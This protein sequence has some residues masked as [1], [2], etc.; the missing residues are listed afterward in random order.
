MTLETKQDVQALLQQAREL[1]EQERP[2]N[3]VKSKLLEA[4]QRSQGNSELLGQARALSPQLI[5]RRTAVVDA[6]FKAAQEMTDQTPLD[7]GSIRDKLRRARTLAI[8]V[9]DAEANAKVIENKLKIVED[10]ALAR[11]ELDTLDKELKEL[12]QKGNAEFR[13]NSSQ[14]EIVAEYFQ[15]AHKRAEH[16]AASHQPPLPLA[17]EFQNLLKL[18]KIEYDRAR[19]HA[20]MQTTYMAVG[21]F[22]EMLSG[23]EAIKRED[24]DRRVEIEDERGQVRNILVDDAIRITRLR[25]GEASQKRVMDPETGYLAEARRYLNEHDPSAADNKLREAEGFPH[26]PDDAKSAINALK[27]KEVQPALRLYQRAQQSALNALS[28]TNLASAWQHLKTAEKEYEWASNIRRARDEVRKRARHEFDERVNRIKD[29]IED[30]KLDQGEIALEELRRTDG[31]EEILGN[32]ATNLRELEERIRKIREEALHIDSVRTAVQQ[33]V[34]AGDYRPAND[35]LTTFLENFPNAERRDKVLGN[36]YR[37]VQLQLDMARRPVLLQES[38]ESNDRE[39]TFDAL[40]QARQAL[41][42]QPDL[43]RT[44]EIDKIKN[45]LEGRWTLLD[46]EFD[47]YQNDDR[48]TALQKLHKVKTSGIFEAKD[49]QRAEELIDQI[50]RTDILEHNL[51]RLMPEVETRLNDEDYLEA[52]ELLS[53]LIEGSLVSREVRKSRDIAWGRITD[54]LIRQTIDDLKRFIDNQLKDLDQLVRLR[55]QLSKLGAQNIE[56]LQNRVEERIAVLRAERSETVKEWEN[57]Q[58]SWERALH[59]NDASVE[60]RQRFQEARRNNVRSQINR[61]TVQVDTFADALQVASNYMQTMPDYIE[62]RLWYLDVLILRANAAETPEQFDNAWRQAQSHC[63]LSLFL[64][65]RQPEQTKEEKVEVAAQQ[66]LDKLAK[67]IVTDLGHAQTV[68]RFERLLKPK[69]DLATLRAA[70]T[71]LDTFVA[72]HTKYQGISRW[73]TRICRPSLVESL[74]KSANEKGEEFWEAFID[75][76][77]IRAVVPDHDEARRYL[78]QA[79][80]H[81]ATL[82][83]FVQ[84]EIAN[85]SG[86]NTVPTVPEDTVNAQLEQVRRISSYIN[87]VQTCQSFF[88]DLLEQTNSQKLKTAAKQISTKMSELRIL[89]QEFRTA[90]GLAESRGVADFWKEFDAKIDDIKKLENGKYSNHQVLAI[91]DQRRQRLSARRTELNQLITTD[92]ITSY[93]QQNITLLK[94]QL[95]RIERDDPYDRYKLQDSIEFKDPLTGN[96]FRGIEDLIAWMENF[97]EEFEA[98]RAWLRPLLTDEAFNRLMGLDLNTLKQWDVDGVL[99]QLNRNNDCRFVNWVDYRENTSELLR[100]RANFRDAYRAV[101]KIIDGK[102]HPLR[103]PQPQEGYTLQQTLTYLTEHPQ[104]K[105]RNPKTWHGR[106]LNKLEDEIERKLRTELSEARAYEQMLLDQSQEFMRYIKKFD[107]LLRDISSNRNKRDIEAA[108][109]LHAD[110]THM[111]PQYTGI[112]ALSEYSQLNDRG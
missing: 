87:S 46:A 34:T 76:G 69:Q 11:T 80:G 10:Q 85:H 47:W 99:K 43:A 70:A 2:W 109:K 39:R 48:Q 25:I 83:S 3:E 28:E 9:Q 40:E 102:A 66:E 91:L 75:W 31:Y 110:I 60:H 111:V 112:Y 64:A 41:S 52:Y 71:E 20:L 59:F 89:D 7:A 16:A 37:T 62:P 44:H 1:T 97:D 53:P 18:A 78:E 108:Q 55:D 105:H 58:R 98:L 33:A 12:W 14:Q 13:T 103:D 107:E 95:A 49:R 24:P 104:S 23:L 90:L 5:A 106:I 38:Y 42:V 73:W 54:G 57:A 82:F 45:K 36:L 86:P 67:S 61:L 74:M 6:I 81:M 19:D 32:T 26:L 63:D 101:H 96:A 50:Q 88:P 17:E 15:V 22:D 93:A 29:L 94:Q 35:L 27:N 84:S 100:K 51:I 68:L 79:P 65:A 30:G 56:E 8:D 92:I 72:T 21:R 4:E 77:R